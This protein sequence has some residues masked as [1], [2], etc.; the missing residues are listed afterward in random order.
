MQCQNSSGIIFDVNTNLT[1][2]YNA[3]NVMAAIAIGDFFKLTYT[4]IKQ[5]IEKYIPKNNR[6]QLTKTERNDLIVD[7]YNA[8]PTSMFASISNFAQIKSSNK[9]LI[10][11]D[12]LELGESSAEEHQQIVNFIDSQ[13]FDLTI[14]VGPQFLATNEKIKKEKF[15]DVELLSIYLKTQPIENKLILIKGSR[16]IHLEKILDLIS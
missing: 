16:G 11:G 14:L 5:G 9:M 2:I 4:E 3:E 7:A 10:L 15:N 6:S 13:N 1:G 12:M 8:N